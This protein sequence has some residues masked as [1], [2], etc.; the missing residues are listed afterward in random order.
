MT[1]SHHAS[2][3]CEQHL[4]ACTDSRPPAGWEDLPPIT[5]H[6]IHTRLAQRA[7]VSTCTSRDGLALKYG[8]AARTPASVLC[9]TPSALSALTA[10]MPTSNNAECEW[11]HSTERCG[12]IQRYH[13]TLTHHHHQASSMRVGRNN[14]HQL[15][16]KMSQHLGTVRYRLAGLQLQLA[17]GGGLPVRIWPGTTR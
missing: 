10:I 5:I 15:C 11:H 9:F 6:K 3:C 17:P 1:C 14:S 16:N 8:S 12:T 4:R 2:C 13:L 7:H